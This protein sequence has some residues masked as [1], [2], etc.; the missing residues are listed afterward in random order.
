MTYDEFLRW[1][2]DQPYFTTGY[3]TDPGTRIT[4]G[5]SVHELDDAYNNSQTEGVFTLP[6]QSDW[7]RTI[8]NLPTTGQQVIEG[9]TY[10]CYY[11]YFIEELSSTPAGYET[12]YVDNHDNIIPS[13]KVK[14]LATHEDG[15]QKII[16]RKCSKMRD[17][18][19][20]PTQR[21][22]RSY[23][24]TLRSRP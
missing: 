9:K 14:D 6:Y 21:L 24:G 20:T 2:Y 11:D 22:I 12:I 18:R 7:T 5:D 23:Q 15:N 13:A 17:L 8:E 1:C 16:N 4:Q 3:E 19:E 10:T